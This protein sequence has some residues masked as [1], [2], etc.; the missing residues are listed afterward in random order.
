ML[1]TTSATLHYIIPDNSTTNSSYHTLQ[2]YLNHTVTSHTQLHLLQGHH[3]LYY[4]LIIH[5]VTNISMTGVG[6]VMIEC[7]GTGIMI[8]NVTQFTIE[9]ISLLY[10]NG[11]H[12]RY[13]HD[14]TGDDLHKAAALHLHTC[15]SV[16]IVNLAMIISIGVIGLQ[17]TNTEHIQLIN[18][19]V[20]V[21]YSQSYNYS[22]HATTG[23]ILQYY[24]N[25]IAANAYIVIVNYVYEG[26]EQLPTI[27]P[28][29]A[30]K[31]LLT[32]SLYNVSIVVM[33]TAFRY[34]QNV[35]I[36]YYY[37]ISSGVNTL[38]KLTFLR[39]EIYLNENINNSYSLLYIIVD[40]IMALDYRDDNADNNHSHVITLLHCNLLYNSIKISLLQIVP[41]N[42]KLVNFHVQIMS[43]RFFS[44]HARIVI[45]VRNRV[46]ILQQM[47]HQITFYNTTIDSH[48]THGGISLLSSVNGIVNFVN[49]IAIY[50]NMFYDSLIQLHLSVLYIHGS[51]KIYKNHVN[52]ISKRSHASYFMLQQHSVLT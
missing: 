50:Q 14:N 16:G 26:I 7:R 51:C 52:Y 30:V 36:L 45:E 21:N 4:D 28:Q 31:A 10:C 12:T 43:C 9:Y 3:Y 24:D 46:N 8:S 33:N 23:M 42:T 35:I 49:S 22:L 29:Y 27:Q 17:A 37:G 18:V 11:S 39:C 2:Y 48:V 38:S 19:R 5:N 20:E 25:P 32:Q 1:N 47:S 44:N 15:G 13:Q 6:E 41:K 40:N 34:L